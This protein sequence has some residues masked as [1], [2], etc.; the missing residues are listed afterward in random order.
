MPDNVYRGP[1]FDGYTRYE[2][3]S[4]VH[5]HPY[6]TK[7]IITVVVMIVA[8]LAIVIPD[9]GAL[10]GILFFIGIVGVMVYAVVSIIYEFV[11][12]LVPEYRRPRRRRR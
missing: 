5:A 8:A 4:F 3:R 10:M 1:I 7:L 11:E 6:W 2:K 12:G 9:I